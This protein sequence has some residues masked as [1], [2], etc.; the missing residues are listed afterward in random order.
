MKVPNQKAAK[1]P[2][3]FSSSFFLQLD[4]AWTSH[5]GLCM[6]QQHFFT[7]QCT[8]PLLFHNFEVSQDARSHSLKNHGFQFGM[9]FSLHMHTWRSLNN[10][11]NLLLKITEL[12]DVQLACSWAWDQRT[13]VCVVLSIKWGTWKDWGRS[14]SLIW[15]Y[16]N[17]WMNE[18]SISMLFECL[19]LYGFP[20]WL[21]T[22]R[23]G[24]ADHRK[25]W[26]LGVERMLGSV[27][28]QPILPV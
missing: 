6:R 3:H 1:W 7:E 26:W 4:I 5:G 14:L 12:V 16:L 8:T 2:K 27:I 18:W 9:P 23:A 22:R 20:Q 19:D 24:F 11:T 10:N 28:I 15:I 21:Q 13:G 25:G 17:E